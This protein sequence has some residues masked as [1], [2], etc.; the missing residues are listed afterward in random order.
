MSETYLDTS[1]SNNDENLSIPGYTLTRADH[2]TIVKR[3]GIYIYCKSSLALRVLN[4]RF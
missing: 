1:I 4:F 3:G 2:P